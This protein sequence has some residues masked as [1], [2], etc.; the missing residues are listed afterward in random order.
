MV[1][2]REFFAYALFE[3]HGNNLPIPQQ[4]N[5]F[6]YTNNEILEKE[7]KNTMPFK[8]EPQKS[9]TWEYT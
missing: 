2:I 4:V 9:N 6:L 5:R 3:R 1:D 8:I 7:Y